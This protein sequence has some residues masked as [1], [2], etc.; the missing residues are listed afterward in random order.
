MQMGSVI[1]YMIEYDNRR[2]EAEEP[3]KNG[4]RKATQAD[5]DAFLG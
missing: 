1:D 4:K 3:K 2:L 5:F